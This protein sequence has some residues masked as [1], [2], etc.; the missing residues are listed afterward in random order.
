GVTVLTGPNGSGKSTLLRVLATLHRAQGGDLTVAGHDLRTRAGAAA[1]RRCLG[2]LPQGG[3]PLGH[4]RVD[5]SVAYAAWLKGVD[6]RR[7]GSL[8]ERALAD[9]DLTARAGDRLSALSGGT[10]QR[11]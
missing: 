1:A 3:A 5:E 9:L 6:R 7:R 2:F 4:L 10:R 8:V 11:A